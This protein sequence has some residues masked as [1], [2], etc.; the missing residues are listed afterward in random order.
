MIIMSCIMLEEH[1]FGDK[2]WVSTLSF[3][4]VAV[5]GAGFERRSL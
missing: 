5:G 1:M 4:A 2:E 3:R